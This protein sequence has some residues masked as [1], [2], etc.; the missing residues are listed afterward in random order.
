MGEEWWRE[1]LREGLDYTVELTD[2]KGR[3]AS[4]KSPKLIY[5]CLAVQLYKQ[6]LI[7]GSYEYKKQLATINITPSMFETS[8]F[9]FADVVS[10][11]ITTDGTKDGKIII[12]DIGYWE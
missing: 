3:K 1:E 4:V 5:P 9:D 11:K 6:D 12:N 2:I 8:D 7:W 10:M